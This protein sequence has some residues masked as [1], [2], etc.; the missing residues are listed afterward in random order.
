MFVTANNELFLNF[1]E[2]L[3]ILTKKSYMSIFLVVMNIFLYLMN[4]IWIRWTFFKPDEQN[5]YLSI[6]FRKMDE[7]ILNSLNKF[8]NRRIIFCVSWTIFEINDDFL[9]LVN[10]FWNRWTNFEFD[11]HFLNSMNKYW[12]LTNIVSIWWTKNKF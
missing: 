8:W 3:F 6:F 9:N 7:Q 2:N 4:K 1:T 10:N 11:E 12:I 5:L